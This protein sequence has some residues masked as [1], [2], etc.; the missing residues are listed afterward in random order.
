MFFGVLF[1]SLNM[2]SQESDGIE[3]IIVSAE[4]KESNLQDVP[5]V[6]DVLTAAQIEDMNITS[7][8]DIDTALPSLIV[9]Y[10]VDPFNASMRIRG[11]GTSQSDASL[12][13]DVALIVDGVYLNKS[14]IGLN[15]LVDIERIEVL[16]GPQG[17]LYGKGS[18]AGVINITTKKPR[19][20]ESD[21]YI[22]YED[23]DFNSMRITS[24]M[25]FSLSESTA[26]RLTAN[27]NES[28]GYMLN[29]SDGRSVNGVDDS[30]LG[31]RIYHENEN[32]SYVFSHTDSS[33]DSSCCAVDS[34]PVS[35]QVGIAANLGVGV[36]NGLGYKDYVMATTAGTP[37]FQLDSTMTSLKIESER[38]N[39]TFTYI[40]AK[41]SY[42]AERDW[43]ADHTG[44]NF[45]DVK[46]YNPG[47]SLTN[48]LRFTSN[49]IG[50]KEYTL[51]LFHMD[52]D[53][54]EVGGFPD[55][56][57][58][59]IGN[60]MTPVW[61]T[62]SQSLNASIAQLQA[63]LTNP[64]V[65]AAQK[66]AAQAQ[67]AALAPAAQ[68]VGAVT[69]LVLNG[70]YIAQ[71]MTWFDETIAVFGRMTVHVSDTLR[72][73]LGARYTSMTKEADLYARTMLPGTVSAQTAA[74]F[75]MP[76]AGFPRQAVFE[77]LWPF[78]S[79][80]QKVDDT[81]SR[82][83]SATTWSASIQKDLSEN[84]MIYASAATGFKAGGY[85]ST[86]GEDDMQRGFDKTES[87]NFEI[88]IKSRLM[89]NKLQINAT[90]FDME[91]DGQQY[92]TQ[93]A[94]GLGRVV[95]N[96]TVPAERLGAD[97]NVIAKLRP[98]LTFNMSYFTL[99][100]NEPP[101][102]SNAANRLT[103]SDAYN[104]GLSHF[105]PYGN[106]NIF[107]RIDYS[108]DG[109][110]EFT[111]QPSASAQWQAGIP[112]GYPELGQKADNEFLNLK[113]G[114]RNET[115]ELAYSVKNASDHK[116][117]RLAL[118]ASGLSGVNGITM[119]PPETHSFSVKYNF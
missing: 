9:N 25:S 75:G 12:E 52:S 53:Y 86:S 38:E 54:G 96:T 41:N 104:V 8:V 60:H 24:A 109:A 6:I 73:T 112:D 51:G 93:R 79:F 56:G 118:A 50:N 42:D 100:D 15:D 70:D 37:R 82:D 26:V 19:P 1:T 62:W 89:N 64:N 101:L 103:P 35:T 10:N 90:V 22:Q 72:Y 47:S 31:I 106:G 21:G 28:D 3:E 110:Y 43:D 18:N 91:T 5:T 27:V 98:N 83:D 69:A 57:A 34:L 84:I 117:I 61:G 105:F 45:A 23:G 2:F 40:I 95:A 114:W 87:T 119:G 94:D 32:L 71:D 116:Y 29:R 49:M 88:G 39:G 59:K 74:A 108:Y 107:S 55:K 85:N 111:A 77:D 36:I 63:I 81:F 78:N 102:M 46:F 4:K 115:W 97:I 44:I 33:K 17:T 113:V 92:I 11:I 68:G 30:V 80:L 20:G 48:E 99:D 67:L 65:P 7:A 58:I 76:I 16:Q 13:S 14:G 66:Q